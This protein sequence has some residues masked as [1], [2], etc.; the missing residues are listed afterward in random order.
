MSGSNR[1]NMVKEELKPTPSRGETRAQPGIMA[2]QLLHRYIRGEHE[3]VADLMSLGA[4]VRSEPYL[5]PAL[6]V[7]EEMVRRSRENL[8]TLFRRLDA[9]GFEFWSR[10]AGLFCLT[11]SEAAEPWTQNE[12]WGRHKFEEADVLSDTGKADMLFPLS[13]Q[14]WANEIGYVT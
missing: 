11:A 14:V 4:A 5:T 6:A 1:S 7:C 12:V 13:V 2:D 3:A 8:M 10:R 9:I